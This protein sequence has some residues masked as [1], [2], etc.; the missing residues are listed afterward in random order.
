[1][2]SLQD[3]VKTIDWSSFNP[4]VFQRVGEKI[5]QVKDTIV[6]TAERMKEKWTTEQAQ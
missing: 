3:A 2:L 5:T 4:S 6:D 1:L